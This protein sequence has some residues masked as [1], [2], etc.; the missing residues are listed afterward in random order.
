MYKYFLLFSIVMWTI[1]AQQTVFSFSEGSKEWFS[2]NDN[3]M[4]G[5]SQGGA[6]ITAEKTLLFSGELSLKNNG[7]FSSIRSPL[8]EIS[9]ENYKGISLRVKG[10]GRLYYVN[11]YTNINIPAGSYRA[12]VQ[13]IPGKW[14]EFFLPFS[15]FQATS[16]GRSIPFFPSLNKNRIQRM[17]FM[18]ADKKQG[19]FALEVSWVKAAKKLS[20]DA[21]HMPDSAQWLKENPNTRTFWELVEGTSF[22]KL[23]RRELSCTVFVVLDK[24]FAT[25]PQKHMEML[26]SNH[27]ARNFFLATHI[28]VGRIPLTSESIPHRFPEFQFVEKNLYV[29]NG[30]IHMGITESSALKSFLKQMS[31]TE[32]ID[33]A[34]SL[35]APTYNVGYP[36]LCQDIYYLVLLFI[37]QNF[38]ITKELKDEIDKTLQTQK[39]NPSEKAWEFRYLLDKIKAKSVERG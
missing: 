15:D 22:E 14:L 30:I 25:Y 18:A 34:I 27:F 35:G 13:T 32:L 26:R 9:F 5:V 19:R 39:E 28:R 8:I 20:N 10:D 1:M 29:R 4:G 3:V 17:G 6:K 36:D 7:G 33:Y 11:L 24:A 21:P 37:M 38:N 31:L 2:V 12:S 16:F 23:L